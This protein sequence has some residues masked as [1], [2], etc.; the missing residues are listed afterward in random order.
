MEGHGGNKDVEAPVKAHGGA[1]DAL[2]WHYRLGHVTKK[3]ALTIESNPCRVFMSGS[4]VEPA[5]RV[6]FDQTGPIG[7]IGPLPKL[8]G[9]VQLLSELAL[10]RRS[11]YKLLPPPLSYRTSPSPLVAVGDE[12]EAWCRWP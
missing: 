1:Q 3:V 8:L 11:C 12:V 5:V 7:P 2:L 4:D 6:Q 9:V 10:H